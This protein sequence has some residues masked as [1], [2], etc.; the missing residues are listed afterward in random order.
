MR[1]INLCLW[2]LQKNCG[3]DFLNLKITITIIWSDLI[4][5]TVGTFSP[6]YSDKRSLI[7]YLILILK[8]TAVDEIL[9]NSTNQ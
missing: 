9:C 6:V 8:S 5:Q 3:L 4:A 1:L 7:N 2:V